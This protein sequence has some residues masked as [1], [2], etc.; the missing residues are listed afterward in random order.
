MDNLF[1]FRE[2]KYFHNCATVLI[3]ISRIW[4]DCRAA[5][6]RGWTQK[7]HNNYSELLA[8]SCADRT[9]WTYVA[10][11]DCSATRI[12]LHC[13]IVLY[14][15]LSW[16]WGLELIP[17]IYA[18]STVVSVVSLLNTPR[19]EKTKHAKHNCRGPNKESSGTRQWEH[20]RGRRRKQYCRTRNLP[21]C[22]MDSVASR[23]EKSNFSRLRIL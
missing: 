4:T 13:V 22:G 5:L 9:E 6:W 20:S 17:Q 1:C 2:A 8:G 14:W 11:E 16:W 3:K 7:G 19:S 10:N 15:G 23:A 21:S 12:S 18:Y